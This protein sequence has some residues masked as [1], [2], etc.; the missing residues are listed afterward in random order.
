MRI[1]DGLCSY[2]VTGAQLSEQLVAQLSQNPDQ[3]VIVILKSQHAPVHKDIAS[4]IDPTTAEARSMIL[5][6]HKF[7]PSPKKGEKYDR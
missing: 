1:S 7:N 5:E 6:F 4:V 3:H 2:Y